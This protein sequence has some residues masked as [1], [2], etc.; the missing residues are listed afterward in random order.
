MIIITN[1]A[2]ELTEWI[3]ANCAQPSAYTIGRPW[4][5]DDLTKVPAIATMLG[6]DEIELKLTE[7]DQM[8]FD[9]MF[10]GWFIIDAH[11]NRWY[12]DTDMNRKILDL[13]LWIRGR[14]ALS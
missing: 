6:P 14:I 8:L 1:R 4:A 11:S 12:D 13:K 5:Y 3:E 9:L 10:A 7:T 2:P